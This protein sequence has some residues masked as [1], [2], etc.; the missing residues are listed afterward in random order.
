MKIY[1]N[2]PKLDVE[3]I[4]SIPELLAYSEKLIRWA[5][6]NLPE[7]HR[8]KS[9]SRSEGLTKEQE[10]TVSTGFMI[11]SFVTAMEG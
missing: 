2:V 6:L 9:I 7:I 1:Q 5:E 4:Q 11:R 3:S 8:S 10:L